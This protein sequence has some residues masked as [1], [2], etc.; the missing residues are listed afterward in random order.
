[1]GI[2]LKGSFQKSA[3][4]NPWLLFA[5]SDQARLRLRSEGRNRDGASLVEARASI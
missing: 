3:A 1:M 2:M 5:F 4:I